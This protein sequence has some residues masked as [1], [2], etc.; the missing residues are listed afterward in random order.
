MGL[1]P[2]CALPRRMVVGS[3]VHDEAISLTRRRD[4]ENRYAIGGGPIPESAKGAA[5][6]F[7]EKCFQQTYRAFTHRYKAGQEDVLWWLD[8]ADER[9]LLPWT[10]L[11]L[12]ALGTICRLA[13][14][15]TGLGQKAD[16]E[17]QRRAH[18]WQQLGAALL[19]FEQPDY[20]DA[21]MGFV[22]DR[23]DSD[24]APFGHAAIRTL[25]VDGI[26]A[27]VSRYYLI[28]AA[29]A[30]DVADKVLNDAYSHWD[31]QG[32]L[33]FAGDLLRRLLLAMPRWQPTTMPPAPPHWFSNGSSE[34]E[35]S[36]LRPS[37]LLAR[38]DRLVLFLNTY[39]GFTPWE[40]ASAVSRPAPLWS[41][42]E[43][44]RRLRRAWTELFVVL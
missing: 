20:A 7:W 21:I 31:Y 42:H 25:Y 14:T 13:G 4:A 23:D 11:G 2:G 22:L 16:Q 34:E 39:A 17:L 37:L 38:L 41:P 24:R 30:C 32:P 43:V 1:G 3:W 15:T 10:D 27:L 8:Q 12:G 6:H 9:H 35:R 36:F 29:A 28:D 26:A 18:L 5:M 19:A 33:P 40:I 44:E